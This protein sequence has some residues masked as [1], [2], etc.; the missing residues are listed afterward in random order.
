MS[1][2]TNLTELYDA[3]ARHD[4]FHAF[5]DDQ[6]VFLAGCDNA[7]RLFAAARSIPGGE[8][9][10]I[11]YQN[12]VWTGKTLPTRPLPIAEAA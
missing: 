12:A 5:S 1:Q 2:P 4:W 9:L 6:R 3:L 10:L 11:A 7:V 8:D